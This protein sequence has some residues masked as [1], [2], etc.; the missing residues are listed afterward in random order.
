[1]A[2]RD[3]RKSRDRRERDLAPSVGCSRTDPGVW[4]T[5]SLLGC[6]LAGQNCLAARESNDPPARGTGTRAVSSSAPRVRDVAGEQQRA[7]SLVAD[8]EQERPVDDER[9]WRWARCGQDD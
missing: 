6:G 5:S 3:E 4:P 7:G 9:D 8:R 2:R 1:A